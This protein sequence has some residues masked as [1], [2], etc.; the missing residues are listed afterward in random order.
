MI[1][2]QPIPA[3]EE[4]FYRASPWEA[5]RRFFLK[6]FMF[7]GR[8][9]RSEYWYAFLFVVLSNIALTIMI[10]VGIGKMN[11]VEYQRFWWIQGLWLLAI[12]VPSMSVAVRRMHDS[13]KSGSLLLIP[14][15]LGIA[16][17]LVILTGVFVTYLDVSSGV[18]SFR[19]IG[20]VVVGIILL[21]ATILCSLLLLCALPNPAGACFDRHGTGR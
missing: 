12:L 4:P 7:S 14:I 9:S 10:V 5:V 19:G 2:S 11:M 20:I 3:I 1:N 6:Y 16:S 18:I 21:F 8:A 15:A 13:N 17:V